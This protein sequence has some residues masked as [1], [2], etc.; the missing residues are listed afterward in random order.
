MSRV[1][2]WSAYGRGLRKARKTASCRA[3]VLLSGY[4]ARDIT[5]ADPV[6]RVTIDVPD[7]QVA[8]FVG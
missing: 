3:D 2:M 5:K 7:E 4:D 6:A 8:R 1:A